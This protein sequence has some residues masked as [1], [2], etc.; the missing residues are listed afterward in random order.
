MNDGPS[1]SL[2]NADAWRYF[3]QFYRGRLGRLAGLSTVAALQALLVLPVLYLIRQAFDIA[4]PNQDIAMLAMI[5]GGIFLI[6]LAGSGIALW[7]RAAYLKII[8][9]AIT[10]IRETLLRKL[11]SLPR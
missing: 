11:Y 7:S 8:K 9:S 4:I 5:G 10:E 6:R 1:K 2:F 3:S